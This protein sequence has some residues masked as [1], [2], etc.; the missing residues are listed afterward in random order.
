M[1][2]PTPP[3]PPEVAE[4]LLPVEEYRKTLRGLILRERTWCETAQTGGER[5]GP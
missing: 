3:T 2:L 5:V 1:K 4:L